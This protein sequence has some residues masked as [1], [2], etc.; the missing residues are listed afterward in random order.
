VSRNQRSPLSSITLGT[1]LGALVPP[2]NDDLRPAI[3]EAIEGRPTLALTFSGG[4]FRATLTALGVVRYL[5]DTGLLSDV[6]FISSVSGGSIANGMLACNWAALREQ[7]FSNESVNALV[8]DPVVKSISTSSLKLEL[9]RNLWKAVGTTT[10]TDLL[11]NAL[12]RRFFKQQTLADL[13][14][15][16]RFI[17]NA[18]SLTTGVRF[19]FERD[20]LGDY[21]T[22]FAS[23]ART[24]VGVSRAVAA[25]AA[26]PG[27]FAPVRVRGI[28]FPCEHGTEPLLVDGGTY[29]NTGLQALDGPQY[30]SLFF[31]SVNAGGVFVAGAIGKLPLV[32]A[33]MRANALLYRQ[34][35]ALRTQWMVERFKAQEQSGPDSA[36]WGRRGVLFALSSD[37]RPVPEWPFED[38]RA[39]KSKDLAFVKTSFDRF[40]VALCRRL[41]YRGW[42]L[43][44]ASL[45][46]YHPG[47]TAPPIAAPDEE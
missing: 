15:Q 36:L 28:R 34:T 3:P 29:D 7:G 11:I 10:R 43:T 1:D 26:V 16:C 27:A 13:D 12:D 46:K 2:C 8:I 47:F 38:H 40:P 24:G 22:G 35:T 23:T 41:I 20:V 45:T 44:G 30:R 39:W 14:P 9:A 17:F 5:A 18:A 37:V 25:S 6:R 31:V 21:V 32:G 42:W 4:G 19:A 33:L